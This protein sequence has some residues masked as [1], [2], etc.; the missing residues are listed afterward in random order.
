MGITD[1][2][3]LVDKGEPVSQ[4]EID[5]AEAEHVENAYADRN[6]RADVEQMFAEQ[7]EEID[8]KYQIA[9]SNAMQRRENAL[10]KNR[11]KRTKALEKVGLNPDGSDPRGR[12]QGV[13]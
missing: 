4:Q 8:A 3:E 5:A 10:T 1:L 2:T 9:L 13:L 11:E 6:T 12:E 7:W